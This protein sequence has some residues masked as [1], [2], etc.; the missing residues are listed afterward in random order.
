MM[1][2]ST[3]VLQRSTLGQIQ[4]GSGRGAPGLGRGWT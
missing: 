1:L 4:S 2:A 3:G